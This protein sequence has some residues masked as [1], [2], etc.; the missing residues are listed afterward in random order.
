MNEKGT[1]VI[2]DGSEEV[3]DAGSE[4]YTFTFCVGAISLDT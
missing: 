1:R 3:N 2:E 4:N